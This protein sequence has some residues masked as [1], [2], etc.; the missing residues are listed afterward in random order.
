MM[1]KE[2]QFWP[3]FPFNIVKD[4]NELSINYVGIS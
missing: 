3:H 2:V 1:K 4:K